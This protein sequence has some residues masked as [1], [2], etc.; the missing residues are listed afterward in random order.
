MFRGAVIM[1]KPPNAD[2]MK[3]VFAFGRWCSYLAKLEEYKDAVK[4]PDKFKHINHLR[5]G[6]I[7]EKG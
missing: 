3:L 2:S 7:D 4:N 6:E 1:K 5:I